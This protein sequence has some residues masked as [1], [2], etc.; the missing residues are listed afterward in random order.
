MRVKDILNFGA[1]DILEINLNN[2]E[3]TALLSYNK[4]S[5]ID[6]NKEQ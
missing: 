1:G 6:Q 2:R 3:K 4:Y 5:I